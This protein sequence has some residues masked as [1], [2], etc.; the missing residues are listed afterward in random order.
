MIKLL[1]LFLIFNCANSFVSHLNKKSL[2]YIKMNNAL[3]DNSELPKFS[4]IKYEEIGFL[5]SKWLKSF[6]PLLVSSA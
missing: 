2:S 6:F 1:N 3:L 5:I 4:E